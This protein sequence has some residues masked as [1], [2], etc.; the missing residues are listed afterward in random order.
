MYQVY[1]EKVAK[2]LSMGI[3]QLAFGLPLPSL[4]TFY[5]NS[6]LKNVEDDVMKTL[7][8]IFFVNVFNDPLIR[9]SLQSF[10]NWC[11]NPIVSA[12][13][14]QDVSDTLEHVNKISKE[15]A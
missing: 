12:N 5:S 6:D 1:I 3:Y 14:S 10:L 7:K 9:Y 13:L 11:S 2:I 4:K 15:W 8:G